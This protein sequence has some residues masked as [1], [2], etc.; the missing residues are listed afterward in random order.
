MCGCRPISDTISALSSPHPPT[1][2]TPQEPTHS[3]ALSQM[4]VGIWRSARANAAMARLFLP[5]VRAARSS[6]TRAICAE[7][8]DGNKGVSR[9]SLLAGGVR[10]QV[11]RHVRHL[12]GRGRRAGGQ[13]VG[14]STVAC[15][16]C[17]ALHKPSAARQTGPPPSQSA[18]LH[19]C[20]AAAADD[21]QIKR[22]PIQ[23]LPEPA[24]TPPPTPTN[25]HLRPAAAKDDS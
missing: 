20:P 21:S 25:L 14:G 15:H 9:Q 22:S 18:H 1:H 24:T 17:N 12:Q 3:P 6:T 4:M 16:T 23:A 8:G 5:G 11:V 2:P 7:R 19:L 13:V 10:C